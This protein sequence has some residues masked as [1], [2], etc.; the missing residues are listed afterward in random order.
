MPRHP[1]LLARDRAV[2]LLID[3]QES[4]RRV[5]GDWDAVLGR[6]SVLL[7]GCRL[8]DVPVL[9]TEQYPKGLGA[10]AREVADHLPAGCAIVEKSSLSCLGSTVFAEALARLARSQVVIAG[11]EAHACVAQTVHD[12]I[13]AGFQVHLARDATA[14]RRPADLEPGWSRMVAA[15]MLPTTVEGALLDL[16]RTAEAPEFRTLQALLRE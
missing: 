12:L 3:F 9:V 2:L 15:G 16:V 6:A 10:T 7:R 14:S 5:L 11:I 4:Y 13:A 8:L 1:S